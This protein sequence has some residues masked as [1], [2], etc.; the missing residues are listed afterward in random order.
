MGNSFNKQ[1]TAAYLRSAQAR[2]NIHRSKKLAR[3]AK[4]KD[5]ICKHLNTG[6]EI[7]AKIWAET[8]ITEENLIPCYDVV[9]SM[10]D[11]VNGL[12]TYIEKFGAPDDMKTT[13]ATLIHAAPKMDCEELMMV[14][15]VLSG[16]LESEFVKECDTN[17]A[18]IN[19]VIAENIDIKKI[20]EGHVILRLV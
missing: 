18:L 8:L 1:K 10:C 11:Q 13:F 4:T 7:N 9:S 6:N 17:Y 19:P 14:R 16:L 15:K 12:L 2:M 5:D 3:I 20:D